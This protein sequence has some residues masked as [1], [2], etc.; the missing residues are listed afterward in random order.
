MNKILEICCGDIR[1]VF[2]AR[3]GGADR[4]ELCS[5]LGEGGITPSSGFI[6][7]AV[8]VGLPVN[9]L[10][11]PR[12]GDFNYSGEEVTVMERDIRYAVSNGVNGVVVGALTEDGDIDMEA[13]K[14]LMDA[15][16]GVDVT[17]HRAF[18]LCRDPRK[19]LHNIISL[20]C[21]TLL[22]S[23][24]AANALAGS[25]LIAG[26]HR[27]ADSK[28]AIMAGAGITPENVGEI[29]RLSKADA[30]HAS[31]S[32]LVGSDMKFVRR[33]VSMGKEA[34]EYLRKTTSARTVG[35]LRHAIQ[36]A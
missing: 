31:A 12:S 1:S 4:I 29:L 23:G 24:Q 9:V 28:I 34:D 25:G 13:M 3:E 26:L 7:E 18:D 17:F 36:N 16:N 20:G 10:I 22:T 2:S 11:R 5:A 30:I 15:A 32:M 14:L 35:E 19:A 8:A 6:A 27:I 21:T 33:G